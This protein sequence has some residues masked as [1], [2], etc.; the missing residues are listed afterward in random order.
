[1]DNNQS[2]KNDIKFLMNAAYQE[3]IDDPN[4]E[5]WERLTTRMYWHKAARLTLKP[6]AE[7]MNRYQQLD[8]LKK[9]VMNLSQTYVRT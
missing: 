9:H 1:M 3:F 6:E 2:L 8:W 5:T 7:K 4:N